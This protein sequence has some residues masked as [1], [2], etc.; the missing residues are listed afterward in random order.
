[1][2]KNTI[3]LA[4]QIAQMINN[5][6][7]HDLH[8]AVGMLRTHGYG[9][10]LLEFIGGIVANSNK[11]LPSNTSVAKSKG[12]GVSRSILKLKDAEPRKFEILSGFESMVRRANILSTN[13]DLRRFGER[14]SKNFEPKKARKE[15]IS[16]LLAIIAE[17][18]ELKVEEIVKSAETFGA[19][20]ADVEFQRLA[21][22]LI[23]GKD[24]PKESAPKESGVDSIGKVNLK[25]SP[26]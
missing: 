16:A 4:L 10:E 19:P 22:F 17:L 24:E 6:S 25:R 23:K 12:P 21:H 14:I 2:N 11:K 26:P 7:E 13:E 5:Y 18:P 1:M 15:T 20:G 3:S 8:L 9:S